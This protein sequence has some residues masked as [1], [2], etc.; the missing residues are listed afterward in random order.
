MAMKELVKGVYADTSGQNGGNMGAIA[1][2]VGRSMTPDGLVAIDAGMIHTLTAQAKLF[3][4]EV[5][6]TSVSSLV[7]TH[8]HSDHVFGAQAFA[9]A[10]VM[11]SSE[12]ARILTENLATRWTRESLMES[13]ASAKDERPLL[14]E[15]LQDLEIRLPDTCFDDE[16]RIGPLK[17]VV[18]KHT[19]GHTSGSSI[20][21]GEES[22]VVFVGD[23]IFQGQFPYAGDP[24]CDPDKWI[25]ALE[26]L[27]KA[28]Y[29]YVVPGH[30]PLCTI[31]DLRV[32]VSH[33]REFR[34]SVKDAV[35]Q[36]ISSQ[37]FMERKL[38]PEAWT[39][40]SE[41]WGLV[42]TEHWFRF[43]ES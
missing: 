23:L 41:R 1:L 4:E 31:D 30:G 16:I 17:D 7:Y 43:Y 38:Y 6:R 11:C 37:L 19:G 12:T 42:S 29:Q 10:H 32:Y 3:L 8:S 33:L 25:E 35:Q 26:D 22:S 27:S 14:W 20:V 9:G 36:G 24:T 2:H 13:Y 21:I 34:E 15:G 28:D 5:T 39:T 40:G 18:I